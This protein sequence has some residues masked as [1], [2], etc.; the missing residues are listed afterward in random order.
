MDTKGGLFTVTA[1]SPKATAAPTA[2]PTAVPTSVP[3]AAA[4][5]KVLG[6]DGTVVTSIVSAGGTAW[7]T[8]TAKRG[9]QYAL[10]T[11]LTTLADSIMTL[12][13]VDGKTQL[14][15][16]DDADDFDKASY[17]LWK[18][19]T[20]GTYKVGVT[21]ASALQ[22]GSFTIKAIETSTKAPT[23]AAT[24]APT[25]ATHTPAVLQPNG[26]ATTGT[27]PAGGGQV[28]FSLNAK[29]GTTYELETSLLTLGDSVMTVYSADGKTQLAQN[30]DV[31][32]FDVYSAI[33]W[34]C[35]ADGAYL[36]MVSG[37]SMDTKG[38]LFTVTATSP[39]ATAAPTASSAAPTAAATVAPT[40]VVV[41][42]VLAVDGTP[43]SGSVSAGGKALFTFDAV[44][45]TT[46]ELDTTLTTLT[47]SVMTVYSA[48]GMTQLA[49]NDDRDSF[50]SSS[51]LR[52]PCA[53]SGKY[54][55]AVT[56]GVP[57]QRGE[58]NIKAKA[59][60]TKA[61]TTRVT[62][63][64]TATGHVATPLSPGAATKGTV[65]AGGGQVWF[66][67]TGQK[68]T[69]YEMD[70]TLLTLSD[71][72]MTLYSADGKTQLA[73]NDD[74]DSFDVYSFIS[75]AC[76]EDGTYLAMVSGDSS[77]RKGGLFTINLQAV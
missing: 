9:A 65:P 28:W 70:T 32:M 50:E 13:S 62:S 67:F 11:T 25:A 73:Q 10:E 75:W 44:K 14:A 64:P 55:I 20:D 77:D 39:K 68:G 48:D 8:F 66:A 42:K 19:G 72:V 36:V 7:F 31:D 5:P 34:P 16:N 37:G 51:F 41:P 29:K 56:G 18:C 27:V 59:T 17:L 57:T 4:A 54:V 43:V 58:F 45:G 23:Y 22:A 47:D 6:V 61:P 69:T 38:G 74:V 49:R 30:D 26:K 63:A 3:T 71:S 60:S 12:Y 53:V 24:S 15:Q 76:P 33:S 21:G 1:T 46:Y 35:P 2:V 52:F 40:V